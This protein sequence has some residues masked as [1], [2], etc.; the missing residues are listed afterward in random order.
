MFSQRLL[1]FSGRDDDKLNV[2]L[3]WQI[4]RPQ[5]HTDVRGI[6]RRVGV[7]LVCV[8]EVMKGRT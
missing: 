6:A 4:C 8:R 7:I 3:R 2:Y 1:E 5:F